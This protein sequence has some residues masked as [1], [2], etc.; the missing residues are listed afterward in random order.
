MCGGDFKNTA[1]G[2]MPWKGEASLV[3]QMYL[4]PQQAAKKSAKDAATAEAQRQ[5]RISQNVGDINTAFAGREPQYAELGSALRERFGQQI[6]QQQADATRNTKFA[7]ARG[8]LTGGSASI[9]AGRRLNREAGEATL[10]GER[11]AQ[12]GV[13]G[14]RNQ[15]ED[16]RLRMISLAQSGNDIGNAGL[17]TA[18]ML[19]ANLAN[20]RATQNFDQLGDL[21][22]GVAQ[23]NRNMNDAAA[24]RRGLTEAQTY[25]RAFQR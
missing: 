14:L 9:D 17:Q 5:A 23:A 18:G 22:G 12:S 11:A 3:N 13:A 4:K 8:G 19:S 6:A 15:D 25:S 10:A 1:G 2:L 20:A 16:A 21:F 24:R 7:L